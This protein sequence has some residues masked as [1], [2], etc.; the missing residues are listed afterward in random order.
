[1]AVFGLGGVGSWAAEALARAGIGTLTLIDC[2]TVEITN[3]N[4]QILALESTLGMKKAEVMKAR[5]ADIN[6]GA[7]VYARALFYGPETVS[8][9][10]LA[11]FDY[12]L[13]AIDTVTSK[14]ELIVNAQALGVPI[15]SSMGT[16]N[17]LHPEKL[18]IA[19]LYQTRVCP[20]ARV[21]R[22]EAKK[23]GIPALE[24]VYSTET[25]VAMEGARGRTPGSMPFVPPA[26][27][28]ILAAHVVRKLL[29]ITN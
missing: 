4:R 6:P 17:K 29:G 26:A 22:R 20:L 23:R 24:T 12:I 8:D 21:M 3:L 13:D 19:D 14:L 28:L 2:D 18:M 27:G 11:Q 7:T 15:I 9:I 1:V 5:I 16:G 10:D 25:P